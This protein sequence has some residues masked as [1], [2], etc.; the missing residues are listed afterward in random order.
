MFPCPSAFRWLISSCMWLDM[1]HCGPWDG[2]HERVI[3]QRMHPSFKDLKEVQQCKTDKEKRLAE[4]EAGSG[5]RS[6]RK[7]LVKY[8]Q[9]L[10]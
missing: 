3:G 1:K 8:F 6:D 2:C 4:E 7:E 9:G 10:N 5:H